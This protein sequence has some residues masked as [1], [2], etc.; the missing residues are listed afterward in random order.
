MGRVKVVAGLQEVQVA[1]RDREGRL[2]HQ[3]ISCGEVQQRHPLERLV[4]LLLDLVQGEA[5]GGAGQLQIAHFDGDVLRPS[6]D[7]VP[8]LFIRAVTDARMNDGSAAQVMSCNGRG[9]A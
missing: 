7:R 8:D 3:P 5:G 9:A 2:E 6:D 4:Q 1:A